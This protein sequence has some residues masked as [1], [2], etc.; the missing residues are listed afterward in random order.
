MLWT[1]WKQKQADIID[2][3]WSQCV[4]FSFQNLIFTGTKNLLAIPKE[5]NRVITHLLNA[6]LAKT[7]ILLLLLWYQWSVRM[8]GSLAL[9]LSNLLCLCVWNKGSAPHHWW[10]VGVLTRKVTLHLQLSTVTAEEEEEVLLTSLAK[11]QPVWQPADSWSV[12]EC[13][14][15]C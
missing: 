14:S 10:T 5:A 15:V 13:G 1:L 6:V 3:Q 11:S 7:I 8:L 2:K 12:G 4:T 9:L